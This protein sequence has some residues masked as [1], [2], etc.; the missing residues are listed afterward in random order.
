MNTRRNSGQNHAAS[1]S[2]DASTISPAAS[3]SETSP[4]IMTSAQPSIMATTNSLD[5][6]SLP[7]SVQTTDADRLTTFS[8][9]RSD[10]W[11]YFTRSSDDPPLKA[12]C[13]VCG[14]ELLTPN[15]ATSSL[16]KHLAQRHALEQF[17]S[18]KITRSTT[19]PVAK[20]AKAEKAKIDALALEAIIQDGRTFGDLQK[21]GMAKLIKTLQ[22]GMMARQFDRVSQENTGENKP[23]E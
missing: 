15:F 2:T 13:Q 5:M 9:K 8:N 4:L 17:G 12:K 20:I 1:P 22:P 21:P 23:V 7:T 18:T 6:S 16:K 19:V 3:T 10:V 14:D 11:Q